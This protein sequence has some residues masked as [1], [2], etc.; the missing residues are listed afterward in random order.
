MLVDRMDKNNLPVTAMDLSFSIVPIINA[1]GRLDDAGFVVNLFTGN[2]SKELIDEII[3]INERRKNL[4][5]EAFSNIRLD[6]NEN[7]YVCLLENINEGLLGILSGKILNQTKKPTFVFTTTNDLIKG[8]GRSLENFDLHQSISNMNMEFNSFGGHKRAVGISFTSM[9]DF[10]KFKKE[11]Q[12]FS[13]P[14]AVTYY[15]KYEYKSF[16][17]VFKTIRSLEP[18]GEGL[19]I[20]YFFI[21]T[22]IRDIKIINSRHTSFRVFINNKFERF[23]A[24]NTVLESGLYNILFEIK[25]TPF[26]LQGNVYKIARV[27]D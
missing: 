27:S 15:I 26:G 19:K 17:D 8:S 21:S 22:E 13:V 18:I 5:N 7:I 1:S 4:T 12:L 24:Y 11:V 25:N 3:S 14:E 20:P 2:E 23:I 9:D 10:L 16:N 6:L